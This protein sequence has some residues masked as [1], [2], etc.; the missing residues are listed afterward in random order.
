MACIAERL[1]RSRGGSALST[2]ARET[3][4]RRAATRR[5]FPREAAPFGRATWSRAKRL[6]LGGVTCRGTSGSERSLVVVLGRPA[7]AQDVVRIGA[8][9]PVTGKESK[10]GS[11]YK[12]ATE[13]AVKEA[14]DAGGV[15]SVA[16]R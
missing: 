11:A 12:Q 6:C 9:L 7:R 5:A 1:E 10:I 13:L 15:R 8:V 2:C 3:A 4:R 16:R 14:N